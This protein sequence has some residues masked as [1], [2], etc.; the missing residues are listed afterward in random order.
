MVQR[1]NSVS[2]TA[3]FSGPLNCGSKANRISGLRYDSAI[4][5]GRVHEQHFRVANRNFGNWIVFLKISF[6]AET[7]AAEPFLNN[8]D[9]EESKPYH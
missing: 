7:G 9:Q 4:P 8:S 5:Y 1:F 3:T 2:K 6:P